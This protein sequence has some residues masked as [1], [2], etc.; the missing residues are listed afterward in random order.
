MIGDFF[1]GAKLKDL[2]KEVVNHNSKVLSKVT[3]KVARKRFNSEKAKTDFEKKYKEKC[4][5]KRCAKYLNLLK[6]SLKMGAVM[7]EVG[8]AEW[9]KLDKSLDTLIGYYEDE[10]TGNIEDC[11]NLEKLPPF[12]GLVIRDHFLISKLNTALNDILKGN[13]MTADNF[14]DCVDFDQIQLHNGYDPSEL[15][16]SEGIKEAIQCYINFM[17]D[18][19][20]ALKSLFDIFGQVRHQRK[21][22]EIVKLGN[23]NGNNSNN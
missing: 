20:G 16:N 6:E 12:F 8:N 7:K 17:Y 2:L 14:L 1:D 19:K 13:P 23:R 18:D 4:V 3:K 9:V 21:A 5:R 11:I 10:Q 22:Q 15:L